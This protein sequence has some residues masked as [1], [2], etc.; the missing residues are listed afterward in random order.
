MVQGKSTAG[1]CRD[2]AGTVSRCVQC[3]ALLGPQL[4]QAVG[5]V[6]LAATGMAAPLAFMWHAERHSRRTFAWRLRGKGCG[7]STSGAGSEPG[8]GKTGGNGT[9]LA[10]EH[11]KDS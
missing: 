8:G 5:A 9:A 7:E 6:L 2:C 11:S 4:C 3:S 1:S 10:A